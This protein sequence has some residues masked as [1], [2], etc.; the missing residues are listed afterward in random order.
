MKNQARAVCLAPDLVAE[1]LDSDV[2]VKI[3]VAP[4]VFL[5]TT[6]YILSSWIHS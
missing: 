3:H 4:L 5:L 1:L 6:M 2:L